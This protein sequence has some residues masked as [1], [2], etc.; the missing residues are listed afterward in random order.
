LSAKFTSVGNRDSSPVLER[1]RTP[2]K[3]LCQS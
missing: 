1:D 2:F 3:A